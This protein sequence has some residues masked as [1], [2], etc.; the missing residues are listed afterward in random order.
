MKIDDEFKQV[1]PPLAIDEYDLLEKNIIKEGCTE[2]LVLWNDTLLDGHNRYTICTKHNIPFK[3]RSIDLEDRDEAEIWIID[4]QSGRRNLPD[5]ERIR[6]ALKKEAIVSK[7]NRA[8]QT[9]GTNQYSLVPETAQGSKPSKTRDEIAKMAGVGHSRV[10]QVKVIEVE[11]TPEQKEEL[12]KGTKKIGT[13]YNEIRPSKPKLKLVEKAP[14][15]EETK[16]CDACGIRRPI[17]DFY[18]NSRDC[19][20]CKSYLRSTDD[21]NAR[22]NM[23]EM[24]AGQVVDGVWLDYE[25]MKGNGP[26]PEGISKAVRDKEIS[27]LE[28]IVTEFNSAI[29][30]FMYMKAVF[31]GQTR[32]KDLL[33]ETISKL[34][35]TSSNLEKIIN[36]MEE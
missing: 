27:Q 12:S 14:V 24:M 13:V 36:L 30:P 25:R 31:E 18:R 1:I 6:L 26:A 4:H 23:K 15:E 17:S 8:R 22:E 9:E 21:P 35:E 32:P 2:A 28:K 16:I 34:E 19:Q 33:E 29:N 7:R 20:A 11:A 10:S 3:T 5:Y